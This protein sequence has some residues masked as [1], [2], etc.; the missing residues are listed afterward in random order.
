MKR[1]LKYVIN[2]ILGILPLAYILLT[3]TK[4]QLDLP[5]ISMVSDNPIV[6]DFFKITIN[7]G[8]I[9]GTSK[10]DSL[11]TISLLP[12]YFLIILFLLYNL[13]SF[14]TEGNK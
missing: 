8:L 5:T 1:L 3:T 2:L 7:T 10:A 11:Y 9:E 4:K 14:K 13:Y 6:I 12:M